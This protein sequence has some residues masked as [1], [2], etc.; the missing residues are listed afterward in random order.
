MAAPSTALTCHA[1]N[2]RAKHNRTYCCAIR[3]SGHPSV[4]QRAKP[5]VSTEQQSM[6]STA[7][8]GPLPYA[9]QAMPSTAPLPYAA[10]PAM[11][12]RPYYPMGYYGQGNQFPLM[13]IA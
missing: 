8:Y 2:G 11:S 4:I 12:A 6:Q 7:V 3:G 1:V 10:M 5:V 13:P 9:S